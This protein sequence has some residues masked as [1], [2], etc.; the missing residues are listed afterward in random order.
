MSHVLRK[1]CLWVLF[2]A[3]L[4]GGFACSG[5][6]N[7]PQGG[8]TPFEGDEESDAP[9]ADVSENGEIE[10]E[11]G[12]AD[13]GFPEDHPLFA[14]RYLNIAHRGGGKLAPEETLPAYESALAAGADMLE[15]D[16]HATSDGVVVLHHD[17]TV[18]RITDGSGTIREMT[19][20]KLRTF[21]AGYHFTTDGGKTFPYRG[22]GVV[23]PTFKEVLEAFPDQVFTVEIK[24]ADPSIVD[25][26][27]GILDETDMADRVIL[28]AFADMTVQEVREKR[29]DIV[30]GAPT[31]EMVVFSTLNETN[32]AE[33][34]AP[35]PFFQVPD[36]DADSL[37]RAHRFGIRVQVWTINDADEMR[38]LLDLGV[39]GIMTDN[40]ALLRDVIAEYEE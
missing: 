12:A 35:C 19:F 13:F 40:P 16:L 31:G 21:D 1:T 20:E 4:L 27:I 33:Y 17:S 26:V 23:V 36:I 22:Q 38:A 28:V 5:D 37:D 6:D 32:E 25:D 7:E 39:D 3:F 2:T 11:S 8:D 30:T 10:S 15:M 18:D 34:V 14:R 29:P 9:D 24:Q